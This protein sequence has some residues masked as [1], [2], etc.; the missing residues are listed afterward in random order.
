MKKRVG[1]FK[2]SGVMA[3]MSQMMVMY[4]VR[5]QIVGVVVKSARV[6]LGPRLLLHSVKLT[7]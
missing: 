7:F 3:K 1:D 5:K 2:P 6:N 4:S